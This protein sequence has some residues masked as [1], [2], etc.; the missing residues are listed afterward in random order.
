M[1]DDIYKDTEITQAKTLIHHIKAYWGWFLASGVLLMVVGAFAAAYATFVTKV[2]ILWFGIL[3]I[4]ASVIRLIYVFSI[5]HKSALWFD[6]GLAILGL[7]V[8]LYFILAP[9]AA[10]VFFTLL[11]A[12]FLIFSGIFRIIYAY[13]AKTIPTWWLVFL[14][15]LITIVLGIL[16]LAHWP[17]SGLWV[18]GLY[19]S[20]EIFLNGLSL[21][22]LALA[23][24]NN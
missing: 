5:K 19:I 16:I 8:G 17:T 1:D 11:V 14:T 2:V 24:K 13:M 21:F 12:I 23:A 4:L 6:S 15:G 3:L 20:I 18:I 10:G 22:M 9:T 7:I